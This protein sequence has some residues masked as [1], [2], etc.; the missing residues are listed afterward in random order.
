MSAPRVISSNKAFREHYHDLTR[1]DLVLGVLNLTPCEETLFVDLLTRGVRFI[2]SALSQLLSKSKAFQAQVYQSIMFPRTKVIRN[3]YDLILALNDYQEAGVGEVV[4]KQDRANC[5]L[6]IHRW[7]HLEDV[8]NQ[9]CFGTL[10]YPFVLQPFVPGVRDVR[11]I[12][13]DDY[14]E[15]YWRHNPVNFRNNLYHGGLS[16][17]YDLSDEELTFCRQAMKRG[18][19]PYAHLD[20]MLPEGGGLYLSEISLRGGLKGARIGK[21]EYRRRIEAI[22]QTLAEKYL[23]S[24]SSPS[25][26]E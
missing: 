6:G 1:G 7:R 11:V 3:R 24:V 25:R 20:L 8:Y 5:G 2:P 15:A 4:T 9:A 22:H 16:G 12:I 21:E 23:A 14:V 17:P 26:V 13:L 18:G 10:A 19:F